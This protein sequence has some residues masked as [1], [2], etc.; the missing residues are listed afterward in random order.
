MST[1][2]PGQSSGILVAMALCMALQMTGFAMFLP[3][4][5]L[6][7]DSFGAGV[8]ALSTSDMA[9]A[10]AFAF[11]APFIGMLAD[12]FGRRP[13]ILISAAG[14]V[15]VF[16]GYLFAAAAGPLILLRGL[17]GILAAGLLPCMTSIVGDLAPENRRAQWVG[18]VTGG[19]GVGYVVGPPLGG[20]LYDGLGYVVPSVVAIAMA[21]GA[22]ILAVFRIPE[23]H[24]PA[25]RPGPMHK[26]WRLA[27]Q[28]LPGRPAFLLLLL[29]TLGVLLAYAFVLPQFMFYA[30]DDLGWTSAQ[31]GLIMSAYGV[32]FMLGA[33]A[34][35]QLSDRV[36]R[37][38]VLVL[39]LALFSAQFVGLL[40][41]HDMTWIA[42]GF[43]AAGLGNALYDPALSAT[44]LDMTPPEHTAS[45][46][47]IKG[48]AGSLG[49][50][51]GPAM[52][53]LMAAPSAQV[54][55]LIGTV[56]VIVLTLTCAF[57]LRVPQK[58]K[59]TAHFSG[60]TATQ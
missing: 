36:G 57:A 22:L 30:Y 21:A 32:A 54:G 46:L 53:L 10:F 48:M 33:F 59:V 23:T 51:L 3:L 19:A 44:I 6:R 60:A 8:K 43:V 28:A 52:V 38:P 16:A 13:V 20:L 17:A 11:A 31:L 58:S 7:F 1:Q 5:A 26:A 41:F 42:V 4:F 15:V 50:M 25:A 14:Y 24:T 12:R 34:L 9:Y 55:F 29:V 39:G 45:M 2:K 56:L 40:I 37:K 47:G 35:G 49:N 27:W 18:I